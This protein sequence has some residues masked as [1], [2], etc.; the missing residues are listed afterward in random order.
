MD[1]LFTVIASYPGHISSSK[2]VSVSLNENNVKQGNGDFTLGLLYYVD[3]VNGDDGNDGSQINPFKSIEKAVDTINALFSTTATII[4]L[5]G[6]YTG[7]KNVN[8]I[9][10]EITFRDITII[11]STP[12][13]AVINAAGQGRVFTVNSL[14]SLTLNGL[15]IANSSTSGNGSAIYNMGTLNVI[16]CSFIN[17]TASHSG[18]AIYNKMGSVTIEDSEFTNNKASD[19]NGGAI[20]S[21]SDI[22]I[23]NSTFTSNT[24]PNS[25]P[26]SNGGAIYLYTG[27]LNVNSCNFTGNYAYDKGGCIY[28]DTSSR[29]KV[30]NCIFTR[31][32]AGNT[33]AI[34]CWGNL[35]ITNS[36]FANNFGAKGLIYVSE[37][38]NITNTLFQN[39]TAGSY[40]GVISGSNAMNITNTTFLNNSATEGGAIYTSAKDSYIT[41]CSF[42]GNSATKY[43]GGAIY[44]NRGSMTIKNTTFS[45]NTAV[46][47]NAQEGGGA[48]ANKGQLKVDN[49]TFTYNNNT[50]DGGAIW[51]NNFTEVMNSNFENNYDESGAIWNTGSGTLYI[52]YSNFTSN[53]G[54]NYGAAIENY[55]YTSIIGSNFT[56]NTAMHGGA[57]SN[58]GSNGFHIESS[59]FTNNHATYGGAIYNTQ[60]MDIYTSTFFNNTATT[61]GAIWNS[62]NL[63]ANFCRILNNTASQA[64]AFYSEGTGLVNANCNWWGDNKGPI[65]R[66]SGLTITNWMVLTMT[67]SATLLE[68]LS[69]A[70]IKVDLLHDNEGQYHNPIG[71]RIPGTL[72]MIYTATLGT[73]QPSAIL[74]M[75]ENSTWFNAGTNYGLAT[76][77]AALDNEILTKYIEIWKKD[78][79]DIY[80]STTGND[81][82]GIGSPYSPYKTIVKALS[83]INPNGR[84]HIAHGVYNESNIIIAKSVTILRD[85]WISGFGNNATIN[86]NQNG[87]IFNITGQFTV[88]LQNLALI[89]GTASTGGAIYNNGNLTVENCTFTLNHASHGGVLANENRLNV[90]GSNFYSNSATT[91]TTLYNINNGIATLHFNRIVGNTGTTEIDNFQ[92][93]VNATLNWWGSNNNPGEKIIGAVS[94]DP[95]LVLNITAINPNIDNGCSTQ[96]IADLLH[97]SDGYFHDPTQGHIMDGISVTLNVPWGNFIDPGISKTVSDNTVNGLTT[98][99]FYANDGSVNASYNPVKATANADG[100][101]TTDSESAYININKVAILAI[102]ITGNTTVI[103]GNNLNYT[104]TITSTGLDPAENVLLTNAF[105]GFSA[106]KTGT[107]KY[108]WKTNDGSWSNWETLDNSLNLNLGTILIGKTAVIEINGTI[109]SNTAK[110]TEINDDTTT[111]TTSTPGINTAHIKT[112][113]DTQADLVVIKTGP[114]TASAGSNVTYIITVTNNGPSDAQNV[115]LTDNI[116]ALLQNV[117]H[118]SFNLGT[119]IAGQSKTVTI[120]GTIPSNTANNT[121]FTNKATVNTDTSATITPS[122]TIT[123]TVNTQSDV[124]LKSTVNKSRP[125]VGDIVTFTVTVHNYGPSDATNIQIRDIMH[126]QFSD[127]VI[128]QSKGTYSNGTWTLDL[129]SG[130]DAV[131]TLTGKVTA[132]MAGTTITNIASKINQTQTDLD[133][134]DETQTS[135]YIPKSNLYL[136]ITSSDKHPNLGEIFTLTYKVGNYGPDAAENVTVTIVLPKG[137][138]VSNIRGNN[139]WTYNKNNRTI[140]WTLSYVPVGD[141]FLYIKGKNTKTGNYRYNAGVASVTY[142]DN[143]KKATTLKL[144]T[145]QAYNNA[146]ANAVNTINM[147]QAGVPFSYLIIAL[148]LIISGLIV[149]KRK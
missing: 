28:S 147:Q 51:N 76:V 2:N 118:D 16:N 92:G 70:L 128:N 60:N 39:N 143:N 73:I 138:V 102:S 20:Y 10:G 104:V 87:R 29:I 3:P 45:Y 129:V 1:D 116:P 52:I 132:L 62:L 121:L 145:K 17:N 38:L 12:K 41:N 26:H 49:C 141:P 142:N 55:G 66:V 88:I 32:T 56:N 50:G 75:G 67:A 77:T 144:I 47:P 61:G 101:T 14:S 130:E 93:T 107:I 8:L 95:W 137:F 30:D 86:A 126:S 36:I 6:T 127:I 21:L 113:V 57:I 103:A 72:T 9:I 64:T 42:I 18:G 109:N 40:G 135:I 120:N 78:N 69:S 85:N 15:V 123:T 112:T 54:T 74:S 59:N 68:P 108:R 98:K 146:Q 19:A 53:I 63:T 11:S 44:N 148:I 94:Y 84:I 13:A 124:D 81:T 140:T 83:V 7:S 37:T 105:T 117:S 111:Q 136:K 33:N 125:N 65:G 91:G 43:A 97:D 122:Q 134:L 114:T 96:V 149:P 79:N 106:F 24:A 25:Q 5:P 115:Q 133:T 71:Y 119:I 131:L 139:N 89:N 4:L 48:I 27:A 90:T 34:L 100:Y 22:T 35:T 23:K 58:Y 82:S 110:G 80:V 31:N 99:K 46:G